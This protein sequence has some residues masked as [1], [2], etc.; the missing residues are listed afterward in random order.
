M[1]VCVQEGGACWVCGRS[2]DSGYIYGC[3]GWGLCHPCTAQVYMMHGLIV[4]NWK[5]RGMDACVH[6]QQPG[7]GATY[8]GTWPSSRHFKVHA[9]QQ[10]MLR[11]PPTPLSPAPCCVCCHVMQA[12]YA[13]ALLQYK[14]KAGTD[15]VSD[16]D[17][18]AAK[19]AYSSGMTLFKAGQLREALGEFN[20]VCFV[21]VSV[22][23]GGQGE[24]HP[25][26]RG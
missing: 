6:S 11:P 5:G 17:M 21:F 25:K 23:G 26:R 4:L 18:A 16:A 1:G 7:K 24:R 20:K 8:T 15:T 19:G 22:F 2:G 14:R 13:A 3:V 10:P 12:D 9:E